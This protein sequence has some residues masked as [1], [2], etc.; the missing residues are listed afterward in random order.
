[1]KTY[2]ASDFHLGIPDSIQSRDRELSIC[3]WLK[4][5]AKDASTIYILGDCF[6]FW[7]EYSSVIPKGYTR[8]LGTISELTDAGIEIKMFK[9]NH[10]MWMFGYLEEECGVKTISDEETI[11][12]ADK[13]LF[14]HHG[15]GLGPGETGYKLLRKIFRSRICQWLFA[16]LHPNFGLG[17][18]LLLSK[19]SRLA[20]KN[21]FEKYLGD[22]K[23]FLTR[24]IA[25]KEKIE[26]FDYYIFG[27][28]HLPLDINIGTARYINLGEWL[29][30]P[31]YAVLDNN[32]LKLLPWRG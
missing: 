29:H 27:H 4:M 5:C 1:V 26:H 13:K 8:L 18:A 19:R 7:F 12:I 6:D 31:H 14:I 32:T 23:E 22:E 3:R 28:R 30:Q 21:N 10:D 25:Q 20:Q 24:F 9:G 17:L 16:R 2:F 11:S 15:D